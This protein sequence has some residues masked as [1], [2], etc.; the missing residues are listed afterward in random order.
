[1]KTTIRIAGL[2]M[3]L[4]IIA[5]PF[6]V[7]ASGDGFNDVV[8]M[9]EQFYHVK[10]Q[11]IPLL[12]RAGMKAVSTAARIKGGDYKRLAEAGSVRVAFFEDQN[13]D[14]RAQIATFKTSMR[15][16][17]EG[18]WS[19]L[20]QT[21]APKNEEQTY[22]FIRDAGAKFHVLVV[23]I[24]RREA[25]VVQATV[26]PEVLAQLM[27]DPNEMGKTLTEDATINDN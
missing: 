12:A 15:T 9:I 13:F 5:G 17:L 24:E 6:R 26:S 10:H 7:R 19:P 3:A 2:V 1:M 16:T 25:T 21:L 4:V 8:K 22:L 18:D 23:T 14:S 11:S 27:K 20:V